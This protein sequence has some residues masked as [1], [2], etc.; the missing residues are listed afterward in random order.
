MIEEY[1]LDWLEKRCKKQLNIF[2]N[3][4]KVVL[5]SEDCEI[6][7]ELIQKYKETKKND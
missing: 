7:L 5:S 2:N 4:G 6:I 3:D 1:K